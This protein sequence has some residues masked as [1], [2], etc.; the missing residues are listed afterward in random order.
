[1]ISESDIVKAQ[2]GKAAHGQRIFETASVTRTMSSLDECNDFLDTA[3]RLDAIFLT[4]WTVLQTD[5]IYS[6]QST[7]CC[8]SRLSRS[9]FGFG[10]GNSRL[11]CLTL[12]IS[13]PAMAAMLI[14]A[15]NC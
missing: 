7:K 11:P 12:K 4:P 14:V 6:G 15:S 13:Q 2:S 5:C 9:I 10:L 1:V 8:A 3:M